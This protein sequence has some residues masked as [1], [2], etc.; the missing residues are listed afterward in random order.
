IGDY[1][2]SNDKQQQTGSTSSG[3]NLCIPLL[4]K[5]RSREPI[6][7]L[8]LIDYA[9]DPNLY[10]MNSVFSSHMRYERY[11]QKP[12]FLVLVC[13]VVTIVGGFSSTVYLGSASAQSTTL[14]ESTGIKG[15]ITNATTKINIVLVHGIGFDG[16]SWSKVIP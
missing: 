4:S 15:T 12:K 7:Y 11:D 2:C 10:T 5:I 6:Y 14:K 13:L 3:G 8:H 1:S 9:T 16:S